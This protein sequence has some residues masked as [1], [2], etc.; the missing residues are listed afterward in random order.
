MRRFGSTPQ[1]DAGGYPVEKESTYRDW[2][3]KQFPVPPSCAM[4][5]GGVGKAAVLWNGR[6]TVNRRVG[7]RPSRDKTGPPAS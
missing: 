4:K 7:C 5:G 2:V 1:T 6:T 3:T